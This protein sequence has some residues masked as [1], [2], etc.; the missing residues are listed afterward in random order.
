V[1]CVG[2]S[3]QTGRGT[4]CASRAWPGGI[5]CA[6]ACRG[7]PARNLYLGFPSCLLRFGTPVS[8][9]DNSR[10]IIAALHRS[11]IP[12]SLIRIDMMAVAM[13]CERPGTCYP[14]SWKSKPCPGDGWARERVRLKQGEAM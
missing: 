1:G 11:C 6:G 10:T 14:P 2:C 5:G 13:S 8:Q 7:F 3:R 9:A 12:N 4:R